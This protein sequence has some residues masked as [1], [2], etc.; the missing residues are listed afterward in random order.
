M[1]HAECPDQLWLL[2]RGSRKNYLYGAKTCFISQDVSY[3]TSARGGYC[4]YCGC[5]YITYQSF[6]TLTQDVILSN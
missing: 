3:P 5:F 6:I 2:K 4:V 1:I